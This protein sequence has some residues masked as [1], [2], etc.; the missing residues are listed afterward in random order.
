[1]EC[2]YSRTL[3]RSGCFSADIEVPLYQITLI[4][5]LTPGAEPSPPIT[6]SLPW[7]SSP[8]T[9]GHSHD[10]R[11]GQL[12]KHLL[13]LVHEVHTCPVDSHDDITLGEGRAW[14]NNRG[15]ERRLPDLGASSS[16]LLITTRQWLLQGGAYSWFINRQSEPQHGHLTGETQKVV[17]RKCW[18]RKHLQ[19]PSYLWSLPCTKVRC[20]ERSDD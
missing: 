8:P 16:L 3:P 2:G 5:S 13:L 20:R 17:G 11:E 14:D 6:L 19:S 9:A 10:L 1:M 4:V 7:W 18:L 15:S 12:Q